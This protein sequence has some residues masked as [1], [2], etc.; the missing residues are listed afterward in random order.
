MSRLGIIKSSMRGEGCRSNQLIDE[1]VRQSLL[2]WRNTEVLTWDL[3]G[4]TALSASYAAICPTTDKLQQ[5]DYLALALC[6]EDYACLQQWLERL[7]YNQNLEK[8]PLF[9]FLA[10]ESQA[11][12]L[13]AAAWL[14]AR[15]PSV[16][17][18]APVYIAVDHSK[19]SQQAAYQQIAALMAC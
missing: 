12:N 17:L 5:A 3:S 16:G 14:T 7:P 13:A 9:I 2:K 6:S 19:Q 10:A 8:I 1:F 15:L 11:T 4:M 18:T